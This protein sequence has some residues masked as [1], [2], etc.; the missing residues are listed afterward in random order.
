M[1]TKGKH[2]NWMDCNGGAR[3]PS[4]RF[5]DPLRS[6]RVMVVSKSFVGRIFPNT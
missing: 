4:L 5:L 3:Q 1:E 2:T 6:P